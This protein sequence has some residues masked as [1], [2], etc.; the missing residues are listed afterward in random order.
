[1]S[2][3]DCPECKKPVSS[4]AHAC[5]FCGYPIAE[6]LKAKSEGGAGQGGRELLLEVKPSCWGYFWYWFFFFLIVPPIIGLVKRKGTV[7]RVFRDRITV[8]RGFFSKCYQDY[9]PR[10]IRSIDVDQSFFQRLLGI[11][12]IA[13]ATAASAEGSERLSS[14]PDPRGLRELILSLRTES[15]RPD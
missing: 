8:E 11:G 3:I 7:M 12:D 5:P 4:E 15:A 13:I 10:D 1:M 9:N 2:L 14:I 6:R